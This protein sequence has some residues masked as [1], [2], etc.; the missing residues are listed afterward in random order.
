MNYRFD[1]QLQMSYGVATATNVSD[2]LMTQ[3]LGAT[4]IEKSS[5]KDDRSG[6]DWWVHREC[7]RSLSVDA[8][9]RSQDWRKTHP[10]E[11]D[12]ALE[13]WSVV[14]YKR[15]GWTRDVAKQT[16][17]IL[18]L[19]QDTGRFCLVPF[20][21]LLTVFAENWMVW[22]MDYRTA[23]QC[24]PDGKRGE[25]HS[26]CVFVPRKVIWRAIYE[27]YSGHIIGEAA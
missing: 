9:V 26:E 19:W 6:T 5:A 3:I 15:I 20:P 17:Y 4:R 24:T 14:E 11:D 21:M 12:L 16:D 1:E 27:R 22:A 7:G 25:Y 13:T 2:I 18:W 8:K 10:R 23:L